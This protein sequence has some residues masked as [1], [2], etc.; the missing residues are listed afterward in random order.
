MP[1]TCSPPDTPKGLGRGYFFPPKSVNERRTS[2]QARSCLRRRPE[3]VPR[4]PRGVRLHLPQLRRF[5]ARGAGLRSVGMGVGAGT[6]LHRNR[7]L[8]YR[9]R[10]VALPD[11]TQHSFLTGEEKGIDVRIALDVMALAHGREYDVA[12]VMS[13]DQDLS[14]VAQEIRTIAREQRRWIK[15]ASAFPSSPTSR[16]HRG[17]DKTD[18]IID[19]SGSLRPVP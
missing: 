11:G 17:I 4:R 3:P 5:G 14:E 7:A 6:L 2:Y 9:N 12:L 16:N 10:T 8:R 13:Q 19:R 15:I 18:W 1:H